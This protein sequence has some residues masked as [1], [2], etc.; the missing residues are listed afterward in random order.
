MRNYIGITVGPIFDTLCDASSSAALWFA[1]N[2]FSDITKRICE[3]I[4]GE[5][6]FEG[7]QIY[8]PYYAPDISMDDGV[9]KF[10][11]RI[12]FSTENFSHEKLKAILN[13]VKTETVYRFPEKFQSEEAKLFLKEY[14]QLH[15]VVQSEEQIGEK[16]C[17]LVLSPFLD[18]LELMK[19]FPSNDAMNPLRQIFVGEKDN[20]NTYIKEI[21]DKTVRSEAN[22]LSSG[23]GSIWTIDEIASS[24][25]QITGP[26]KRKKYYAVVS[27]DGDA[28][29]KFLGQI[30][31]EQVTEFSR[32]CLEYDEEATAL[33][34]QY[35]GMTIYA[36][37][38]D[39]LF[40]AP[41]MTD[42]SSVF[43]L[44]HDIQNM[45]REKI[46][47]SE[48][49]KDVEVIP[50]ISFGIAVQYIKY[51]LYEALEHARKLLALAKKDGDFAK[52]DKK[53]KKNNMAIELQKHSGQSIEL[54]VANNKYGLLEQFMELGK[55][56]VSE[57]QLNSMVYTLQLFTS[58]IE[59]LNRQAKAENG[60]G[61]RYKQ[62]WC[63]LFDNEEQKPAQSYIETVCTAYYENFVMA[64]DAGISVPGERQQGANSSVQTLI[65]LLRLKKFF[66]EEEGKNE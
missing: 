40:L 11:D 16:N 32:L 30:T 38:D 36:G 19:T 50:T 12:I 1:S 25:N 17:V 7:T 15:Y 61:E 54:V 23:D 3:A 5:C 63:N 56:S 60:F 42:E 10:H 28:M 33:I 45:F 8:S 34:G 9:G 37:G 55:S 46:R 48:M 22:Q 52:D 57:M 2:L 59:V 53:C 29:G 62:A 20:R 14:L 44:C 13:T 41:V 27:A 65:S 58:L 66:T 24:H 31:S 21:L 35:G 64:E 6:G 43:K 18:A 49:F 4:I 26:W 47:T 51:P 39:L